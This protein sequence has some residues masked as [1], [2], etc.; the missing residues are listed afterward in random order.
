MSSDPQR[1]AVSWLKA[2]VHL[3]EAIAQDA[4]A[5][6]MAIAHSSY[7]AMFH[8]VRAVLFQATGTAPKRHDRTIQQFGLLVQSL[9]D[10]LR[11][12]GKA[13]NEAKDERNDADY[14][15]AI[16]PS[17]NDARDALKAAAHFLDACRK[18]F[19]FYPAPSVSG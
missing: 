12:A 3:R 2:E 11:A 18:H 16:M 10:S 5:S 7:Y 15:E 6:P 1:A 14:N 4:E 17:P 9:D 19:G 8:A 13:F